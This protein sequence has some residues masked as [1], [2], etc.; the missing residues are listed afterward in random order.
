MFPDNFSVISD[1]TLTIRTDDGTVINH[2]CTGPLKK[3]ETP[4]MRFKGNR[5][6]GY[7]KDGTRDRRY[8]WYYFYTQAAI[9][10][11]ISK[12]LTFN[13]CDINYFLI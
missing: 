4:D 1:R 11:L 3:D 5:I 12:F 9:F 6:A 13:L 10:W 8:R 2:T 7:N